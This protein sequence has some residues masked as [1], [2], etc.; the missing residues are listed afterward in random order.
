MTLAAGSAGP[1]LLWAV[2]G[3]LLI[4]SHQLWL[5]WAGTDRCEISMLPGSCVAAI[6]WPCAPAWKL[7]KV[8]KDSLAKVEPTVL[9]QPCS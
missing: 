4:P 1:G 9:A 6:S 3:G 8:L 2:A 7:G 5:F